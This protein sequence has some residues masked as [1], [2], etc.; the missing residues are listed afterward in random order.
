MKMNV[1]LEINQSKGDRK[2]AWKAIKTASGRSDLAL[3]NLRISDAMLGHVSTMTHLK[4]IDLYS[5]S[6][7]TA[8]GIQHL[9]RLPRLEKLCL[10]DTNVTDSGLAG[11]EPLTSLKDLHLWRTEVTD[12]GLL[13]LRC[14]SSLSWLGLSGC[15]GVTNA[16]MVHVGKLTGLRC[17][18][19]MA[20]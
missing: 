20:R 14:L 3:K 10:S 8:E 9:Y 5:S 1:G 13:H 15:K 16:S 19:W 6:G 4:E 12:A 11:I 17:F 18:G 2:A 7:F